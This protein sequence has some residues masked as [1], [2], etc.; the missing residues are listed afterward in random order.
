MASRRVPRKSVPIRVTLPVSVA[1]DLEKLERALA[2]VSL[3]VEARE[4]PSGWG[5]YLH[6]REFVVDAISL[7][8]KEAVYAN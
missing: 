5:G 1:Y 4:W 8:V 2:N 3:F 7:E 6:G